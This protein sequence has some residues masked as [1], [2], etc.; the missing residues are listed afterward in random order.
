[1]KLLIPQLSNLVKDSSKQIKRIKKKS[2]Q[3]KNKTKGKET[4]I[5]ERKEK[6]R[7]TV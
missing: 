3:K 6:K 2:E 1:M 7:F 5:K 4:K